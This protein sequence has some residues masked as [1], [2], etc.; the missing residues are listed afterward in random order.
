MRHG[1][2]LPSI[3]IRYFFFLVTARQSLIRTGHPL[4]G[5]SPIKGLVKAKR[6]T[7]PLL[8]INQWR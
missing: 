8:K 6:A 7:N 3:C 2:A 4:Q 1:V 5:W